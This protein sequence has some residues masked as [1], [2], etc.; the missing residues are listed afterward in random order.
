MQTTLILKNGYKF[1]GTILEENQTEL[2]IDDIKLGRT[3][4]DKGSISAR[5]DKEGG[6]E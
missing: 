5:S 3:T 1:S 2:I 4:V 6:N